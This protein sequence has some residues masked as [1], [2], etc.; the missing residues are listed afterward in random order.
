MNRV[1]DNII[2]SEYAEIEIQPSSLSDEEIKPPKRFW[3]R[4]HFWAELNIYIISLI[5]IGFIVAGHQKK[6]FIFLVISNTISV[7]YFIVCKQYILALQQFSFLILSIF[8][9]LE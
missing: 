3:K 5:G 6:G 9:I 1:A 8:G 4:K 7:G 2:E